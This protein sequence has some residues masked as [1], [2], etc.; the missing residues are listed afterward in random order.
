M[1]KFFKNATAS[2]RRFF[3]RWNELLTLGSVVAVAAMPRHYDNGVGNALS[4]LLT[5]GL[6]SKAIDR[7]ADG[8]KMNEEERN[9]STKWMAEVLFLLS[10]YKVA[11]IIY[12]ANP[13]VCSVILVAVTIMSYKMD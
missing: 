8:D 11:A 2:V 10:A 3:A 9:A 12:S 5:F 6:I 1:N 4:K 7:V 13:L